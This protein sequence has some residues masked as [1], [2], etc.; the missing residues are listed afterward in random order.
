MILPK[1]SISAGNGVII[2]AGFVYQGPGCSINGHEFVDISADLTVNEGSISA[3]DK[4]PS[5]SDIEADIEAWVWGY[6]FDETFGDTLNFADEEFANNI[7]EAF[8]FSSYSKVNASPF[9]LLILIF[10]YF[11]NK[12]F[13]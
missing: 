10:H 12:F 5:F 7:D 6:T 13:Q 9:L 2:D 11:L 3:G 8:Q 4:I 1:C